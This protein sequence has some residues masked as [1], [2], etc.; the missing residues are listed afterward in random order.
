MRTEINL[1]KKEIVNQKQK[2]QTKCIH[3]I[4]NNLIVFW[5]LPMIE[6]NKQ[7]MKNLDDKKI[8]IF[9]EKFKNNKIQQEDI[10]QIKEVLKNIKEK[11]NKY[12]NKLNEQKN[13]SKEE[14]KTLEL[15][16][17]ALHNLEQNLLSLIE[18]TN[19]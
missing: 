13:K 14:E 16:K 5:F 17:E 1:T 11:F 6:D 7:D 19:D 2:T 9:I 3:D 4:K 10:L 18:L 12:Q 8:K 15:I